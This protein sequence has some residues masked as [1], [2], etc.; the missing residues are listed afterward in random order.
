MYLLSNKTILQK[1]TLA[2]VYMHIYIYIDGIY[3]NLV[4][5]LN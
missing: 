5:I 3:Y 2:T 4:G 1:M